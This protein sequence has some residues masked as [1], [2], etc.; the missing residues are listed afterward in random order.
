MQKLVGIG[1]KQVSV[2]K[3]NQSLVHVKSFLKFKHNKS[4]YLLCL[5]LFM[6]CS[7]I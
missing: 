6:T 3:Y 2:E 5:N 1:V 7:T 4:N